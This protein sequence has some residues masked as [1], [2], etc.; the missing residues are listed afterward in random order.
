MIKDD[1]HVHRLIA[2]SPRISKIS[3]RMFV[4]GKIYHRNI[5]RP[6]QHLPYTSISLSAHH[7]YIVITNTI[8]KVQLYSF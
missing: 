6:N 1:S 8:I 5:F 4:S 3:D 2:M 7:G